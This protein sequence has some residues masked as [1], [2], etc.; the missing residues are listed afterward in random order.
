MRARRPTAIEL[1]SDVVRLRRRWYDG[2]TMRWSIVRAL[3]IGVVGASITLAVAWFMVVDATSLSASDTLRPWLIGVV[4][5]AL[6]GSAL[7]LV[8]G[9]LSRQG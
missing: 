4:M 6:C 9:R 7:V 2:P 5:I 1:P 8:L 3:Q